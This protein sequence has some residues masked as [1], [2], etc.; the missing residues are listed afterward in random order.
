M[1][2]IMFAITY[3]EGSRLQPRLAVFGRLHAFGTL[4]LG[5]QA[6]SSIASWTC[7]SGG[8]KGVSPFALANS[9]VNGQPSE[10]QRSEATV[11]DT[12]SNLSQSCDGNSA[13]SAE[14]S[15]AVRRV[16]HERPVIKRRGKH[17]TARSP[18]RERVA[19]DTNKN[20]T[21]S[22]TA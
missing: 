10:S 15:T 11:C 5:L 3:H 4:C 19:Y 21:M 9:G 16:Y 7:P 14:G 1:Y 20:R 13:P 6:W 17:A 18:S 22:A 12:Y 8:C 2:G